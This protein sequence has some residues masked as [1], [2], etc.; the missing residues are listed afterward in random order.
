MPRLCLILLCGLLV[1]PAALAAP[2]A[3]GDGV[4]ELK[5]VYGAVTIAGKGAL[6]G[7]VDKGKLIVTDPAPGDGDV[8]V[9]GYDSA[10]RLIGD[11]TTVYYGRNMHFRVT[12]GRYKLQ[13]ARAAGIDLTAVGVGKALVEPDL[14]VVDDGHY[15]LDGGKWK[16]IPFV[17]FSVPFGAQLPFQNGP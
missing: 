8:Y 4:L 6:W 11:T 5:A 13:F 12:G 15:A 1:V 14:S 3:S 16:P 17:T 9:S 2:K 7:Q 10:P